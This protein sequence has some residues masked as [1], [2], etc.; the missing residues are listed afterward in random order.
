MYD[1]LKLKTNIRVNGGMENKYI[2]SIEVLKQE[3]YGN[4]F[5][6]P[7]RSNVVIDLGQSYVQFC[8]ASP[9]E[10]S[11]IEDN[12]KLVLYLPG[13]KKTF[14]SIDCPIG[15]LSKTIQVR[16]NILIAVT[17]Y[18]ELMDEHF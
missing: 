8:S 4:A 7:E 12:K 1:Y 18:N 14:K 6:P 2:L 3:F 17:K 15:S 9:M 11:I 16:N 13:S 10:L 5:Y